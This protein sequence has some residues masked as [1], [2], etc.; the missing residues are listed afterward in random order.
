MELT[1]GDIRKTINSLKNGKSPGPDRICN[2][3]YKKFGSII[4][5]F[6]LRMYKK[7]L[8]GGK[9]PSTLNEAKDLEQVSLLNSDLKILAKTLA[10]RFSPL[11]TKLTHPVYTRFIPDRHL[12]HNVRHLLNIRHPKEE[13]RC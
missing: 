13:F 5:S 7:S 9:L 10:S 2:E 1:E 4:S 8:E 6:L 3:L 12:F 11:V